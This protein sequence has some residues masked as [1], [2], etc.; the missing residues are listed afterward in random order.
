MST[1]CADE[2][3]TLLRSGWKLVALE[4]FEE[5]RALQT[6]D[7]AARAAGS[8]CLT[9]SVASGLGQSGEGAGSLDAGLTAIA[10]QPAEHWVRRLTGAPKNQ[11]EMLGILVWL[12]LHVVAAVGFVLNV[13]RGTEGVRYADR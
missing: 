12:G 10:A 7:R 8:Q 4:T 11:I 1:R 5:E 13:I 6:L 2:L 3:R 9:W